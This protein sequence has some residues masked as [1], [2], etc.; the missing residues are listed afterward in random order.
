MRVMIYSELTLDYIMQFESQPEHRYAKTARVLNSWGLSR[1][2]LIERGSMCFESSAWS[3]RAW[4]STEYFSRLAGLG[5]E[6]ID[7]L[8]DF[9]GYQTGVVLK[10]K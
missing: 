4:F 3:L 1:E 10:G 9:Y 7:I 6:V 8:P 5:F 2:T